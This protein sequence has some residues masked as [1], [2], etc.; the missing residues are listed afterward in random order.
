MRDRLRAYISHKGISI[1]SFCK[2]AG[3]ARNFMLWETAGISARLMQK[4][5]Q[6]YPD[7]NLHW[8]ATGEGEMLKGDEDKILLSVHRALI[9]DREARIEQLEGIVAK[10]R[11][12]IKTLK[13]K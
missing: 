13:N 8:V 5:G 3:L 6:A 1:Y 12:K 4:I 10:L 11:A 7:L 9:S 2:Q